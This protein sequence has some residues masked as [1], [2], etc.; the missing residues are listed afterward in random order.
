M[1]KE[2]Q[3]KQQ[4]YCVGF[5]HTA[6]GQ[7]CRH[8]DIYTNDRSVVNSYNIADAFCVVVGFLQNEIEAKLNTVSDSEER[9]QYEMRL[10]QLDAA[11][12]AYQ[13][14]HTS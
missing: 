11:W 8:L 13:T 1:T 14:N 9:R 5:D 4:A 12:L 3:L 10:K 2:H 7:L 6:T